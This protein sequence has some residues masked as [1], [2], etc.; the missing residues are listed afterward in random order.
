MQL[1]MNLAQEKGASSWLTV[2]LLEEHRF[3]L[4]KRAFWDAVSLRYGWAPSQI[5]T[6]CAC[7]HPFTIHHVLS[8]P[9]GGYP[10]IRHNE[11]GDLT[12]DLLTEIFRGVAIEPSLQPITS[13]RLRGSTTNTQ[14]GA[15]M[16][17]VASGFW[18][19]TFERAFFDISV[20]NP[21]A[22]SNRYPSITTKY[23]QHENLKKRHYKQRIRDIEH[24]SF[25]PLVFSLTGGMDPTASV[26]K[27]T[28]LTF[29]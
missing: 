21:L 15:R 11:L 2:L 16:D 4:H 25:S 23:R 17:I 9:K 20:F 10:S 7:G 29:G 22:P 1:A 6:N 3:T 12:A 27:A 5:P 14:D 24:S 26:S 8:C 19:G 28:S 18:G 13:E